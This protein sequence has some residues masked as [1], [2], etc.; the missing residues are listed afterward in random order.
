MSK[1]IATLKFR[2]ISNKTKRH[3]SA[4]S[5]NNPPQ[6]NGYMEQTASL[7][8]SVASYMRLPAIASTVCLPFLHAPSGQHLFD[9]RIE[10]ADK[11]MSFQGIAAIL[12]SLLYF[13][14]KYVPLHMFPLLNDLIISEST[15]VAPSQLRC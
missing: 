1:V 3:R 4:M 7:L 10:K 12:T 14:Q 11:T 8:G 15:R 9:A 5:N 13:K 6:S 2:Q